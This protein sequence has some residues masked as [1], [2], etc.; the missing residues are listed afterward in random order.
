MARVEEETSW[1][2][3][4]GDADAIQS[5]LRKFVKKRGMNI[6]DESDGEIR[7]EQG[8]NFGTRMLGGWFVPATWLPKAAT[9]SVKKTKTGVRVR[10]I[11]EETLGF[12]YLDPLL[13]SKYQSFFRSWI[14]DLREIGE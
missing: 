7:A 11:I 6:V 10:A 9:I 8:T 13:A 14:E 4:D 2:V 5:R 3:E 12:G 1:V